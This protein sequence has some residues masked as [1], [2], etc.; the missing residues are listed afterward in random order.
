MEYSP[1][2]TLELIRGIDWKYQNVLRIFWVRCQDQS[3][4]AFADEVSTMIGDESIVP[5]VVRGVGF[6]SANAVLA[7]VLEIIDENKALFEAID[8]NKTKR[9]TI[10]LL[11]KDEFRLSQAGSPITLPEWFP[12]LPGVETFFH[13]S[14]IGLTAEVSMLDCPEA[15]IEHVSMLVFKLERAI[16]DKLNE[17]Y[18]QNQSAVQRFWTPL[19]DIQDKTV[20]QY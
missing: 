11:A 16:V 12:V 15:R 20:T 13:I 18:T 2:R 4:A 19:M 5:V 7:D 10:L 1:N 14:D 6:R 3:R 8:R 17:L 9:V